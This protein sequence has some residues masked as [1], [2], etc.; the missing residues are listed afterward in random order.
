MVNHLLLRD[1]LGICLLTEIVGDCLCI[2]SL[3]LPPFSLLPP[4]LDLFS[5]PTSVLDFTAPFFFLYP[6]GAGWQVR[7][8][9]SDA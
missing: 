4:L 9:L 7:K 6:T 2:S 1:W 5:R 8:Q 3:G